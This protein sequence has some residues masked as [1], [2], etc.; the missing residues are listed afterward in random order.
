VSDPSV[1]ALL[2]K[3]LHNV[4]GD[5]GLKRRTESRIRSAAQSHVSDTLVFAEQWGSG[6][7]DFSFLCFFDALRENPFG[8]LGV[9]P[10]PAKQ[11][12]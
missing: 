3:D 9:I 7:E 4:H 2:S 8:G 5:V 12:A 1:L 6:K 11:L 10:N